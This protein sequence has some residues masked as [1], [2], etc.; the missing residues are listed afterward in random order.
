MLVGYV[1]GVPVSTAT[2]VARDSEA[3]VFNVG[4]LPE[5][6]KRGYGEAM[7]WAAIREGISLGCTSV[8]LQAT[9]MGRSMYQHMG[10]AGLGPYRQLVGR[11]P[12]AT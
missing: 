6:R 10:F 1:N 7:T 2:L 3:C 4:T 9:E 11:N 12:A 8:F 5:N